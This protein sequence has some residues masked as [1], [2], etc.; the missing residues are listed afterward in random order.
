[1][2]T[3]P[4]PRIRILLVDDHVLIRQGLRMLLDNAGDLEVVGEAARCAD[5]VAAAAALHPDIVLL[6]LDLG[7]ENGLDCITALASGAPAPR[8]L[9]LTGLRDA[10]AHRHAIRLGAAGIVQKEQAG[11]MLVKA[12]RRVRAGEIWVDRTLTAA[13]FG[14]YRRDAAAAQHRDA[15]AARI[16]ELTPRERAIVALVA[17]GLNTAA[18][19]EHLEISDKT[20]RNHLSAVYDKL[21]VRDRLTLALYAAR[22]GLTAA[23]K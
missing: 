3:E 14:D 15:D 12:I 18:I 19:G 13:I 23:P 5:A 7:G 1:M 9:V 21:Q 2:M 20:V 10:E 11:E 4:S 16:A 22:H 8:V 6:D 17:Q